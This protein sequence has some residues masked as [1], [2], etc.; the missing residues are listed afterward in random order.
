MYKVK[1]AFK[2]GGK[3]LYITVLCR[4]LTRSRTKI[5]VK[6]KKRQIKGN[7]FQFSA[8]K[9]LNERV[10]EASEAKRSGTKMLIRSQLKAKEFAQKMGWFRK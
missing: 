2:F 5:E 1:F 7:C 9:V 8:C 4:K 6:A 3:K 10:H